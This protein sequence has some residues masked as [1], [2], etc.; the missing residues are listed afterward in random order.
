[1]P[2]ILSLNPIL[3]GCQPG[4]ILPSR[5]PRSTR[6][7]IG[8]AALCSLVAR[9]GPSRVRIALLGFYYD[10]RPQRRSLRERLRHARYRL[11]SN[12]VDRIIVH[13]SAGVNLCAESPGLPASRFEFIPYYA[14]FDAIGTATTLHGDPGMPVVLA[15]GRHRD[16]ACYCKSV[17]GLVAPAVV[18][19]GNSGLSEAERA[20]SGSPIEIHSEL[21]RAE[22]RKLS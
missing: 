22:Y 9:K 18:V 11:L 7:F 19:C 1:M 20:A 17:Q 6:S 5:L 15:P 3:T 14:Y 13:T 21:P 16:F 8:R 2:K 10:S 4:R 12:A